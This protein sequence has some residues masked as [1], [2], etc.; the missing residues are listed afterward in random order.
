[1]SA[2]KAYKCRIYPNTNQKKYFSKV[3]GCVRFLY[4]KMLSDKKDYYK[5]NG[6]NL[7]TYPSKYKEEF[8]FLKEVDSLALCSAWIDLNFAYSNFFRE[9]KKGNKMQG[10]PKYKSKKNRQTY[11]TNNQ[12]NSIR[13]ENGYIKLPKIG[14]IK[15][16]L[17]RCIKDNELVKNVVVE[18]DT[19]DK[20]YISITV[21]CLDT[22]NNN[23]TKGDKK[24]IVG[25]DMSMKHF[26]V[27]SGGEKI[28]HPK[29]LLKNENKLK[30]Y[31]RKLSK[32]QKGSINRAKSRLRVAKLHKKISN[33]RKDF[34][35]KLSY[36]FVSNYKNIVIENLSIK[37]MQKGMFGK[38][39][40]DLGWSEFVRQLSYKSEWYGSSLYKVDRDFPSS[41]LCSSCH[42]KNTTL[43]LSDAKWTC[44]S[45]N[46]LHDRDI[47]TSLNLKAYS[48]KEIKTK[49]GT[50]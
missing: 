24:E 26:L 18:K 40:N 31:Q 21:E 10:F 50:A 5:N 7:I 13:I 8:P 23:E 34:L 46:T 1:M 25:I 48:Y 9:I 2:N 42:I 37:G 17:H 19:D 35:H 45:C 4:N 33:Q 44:S 39:I 47:N 41:K 14:F 3:F 28:N 11:R 6:Q 15:L 27:S 20:Y 38:S 32:K 16:C 12:K 22:K 36:Y 29:Y 49:A 30:K 43:R